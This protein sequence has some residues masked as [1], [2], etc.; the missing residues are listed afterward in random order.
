MDY[1]FLD[2]TMILFC[3]IAKYYDLLTNSHEA[4]RGI[5][6]VMAWYTVVMKAFS[7]HRNRIIMGNT[8]GFMTCKWDVRC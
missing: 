3:K 4:K 2:K 6:D 1:D 5:L 7:A 8:C